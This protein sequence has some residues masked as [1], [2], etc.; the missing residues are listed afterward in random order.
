MQTK[1]RPI[2]SMLSRDCRLLLRR[3]RARLQLRPRISSQ[4]SGLAGPH[5]QAKLLSWR[6]GRSWKL[7]ILSWISTRETQEERRQADLRQ[8]LSWS[9]ICWRIKQ[10]KDQMK[11]SAPPGG[12][13]W[14]LPSQ[15]S[16]ASAGLTVS[17]TPT[18]FSGGRISPQTTSTSDSEWVGFSLTRASP[19]LN[20][21]Q[22]LMKPGFF[23]EDMYSI[24][25]TLLFTHPRGRVH[26]TNGYLRAARHSRR[27]WSLL[28]SRV[29]DKCLVLTSWLKE[30]TWTS[31][32][33][34]DFWAI[35]FCQTW[36]GDLGRQ[37]LTPPGGSR[38]VP[39]HTLLILDYLD[40]IFGP[41]M[42]ALKSRQGE[43]WAPTSPD[44]SVCDFW[45]WGYLKEK[46][47]SPCPPPWH[48]SSRGSLLRWPCR[49]A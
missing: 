32:D 6:F 13:T 40:K 49:A 11:L 31:M 8:T 1:T 36:G 46:V 12:T 33:T 15:P 19:G 47:Y 48:S 30:L 21:S 26:L 18:Q 2:N 17:S 41:N 38:M 42:L 24:E 25:K 22:S 43:P 9:R 3:K 45:L 7:I 10:T 4:S 35:V 23:W 34:K 14:T 29:L 28:L 39:N 5:H 27:W 44:M 16:T 20:I 37:S